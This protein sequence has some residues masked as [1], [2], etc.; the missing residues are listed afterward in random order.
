MEDPTPPCKFC[1]QSRVVLALLALIFVIFSTQPESKFLEG[2]DVTKI[3]TWI[4]VVIVTLIV[5]GKAYK[6]YWKK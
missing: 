1:R 5:L 4:L 2:V 3:F 6:E